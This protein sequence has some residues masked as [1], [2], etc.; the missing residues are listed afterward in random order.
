MNLKLTGE[1]KIAAERAND[2]KVLGSSFM[3]R[4]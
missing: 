1:N 3:E 2:N 4:P